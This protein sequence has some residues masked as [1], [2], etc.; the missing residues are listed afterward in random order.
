MNTLV[1]LAGLLG[2][3][4]LILKL[5][6]GSIAESLLKN[7]ETKAKVID[8]Q[9]GIAKDDGLLA[10][11]Q[12]KRDQM[13]KDLEEKEKQDATK[14]ELLDFINRNDPNKPSN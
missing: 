13:Q 2:I 3:G 10:A 5:M 4:G 7:Q 12:A 1:I 6:K 9:T 8:I 11:E 14:D